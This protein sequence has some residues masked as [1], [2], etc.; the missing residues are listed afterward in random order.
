MILFT[1]DFLKAIYCNVLKISLFLLSI[2]YSISGTT[3][4]S[5]I[6]RKPNPLLLPKES[7]D[8][9]ILPYSKLLPD[10]VIQ[11]VNTYI[12]PKQVI[13]TYISLKIKETKLLALKN[14]H[15][16]LYILTESE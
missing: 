7:I 8:I 1:L 15:P 13:T 12:H 11:P 16:D 2:L 4:E 10:N 5:I 3:Q 6:D 9:S 14:K